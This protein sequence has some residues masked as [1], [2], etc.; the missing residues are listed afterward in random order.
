VSQGDYYAGNDKD[1]INLITPV[2]STS[3]LRVANSSIKINSGSSDVYQVGKVEQVN[4]KPFV[5]S[6]V[7][8][9]DGNSSNALPVN[10][11]DR[12]I[13]FDSISNGIQ[14]P[15]KITGGILTSYE[16]LY[17][18]PFNYEYDSSI[19][20]SYL[21]GYEIIHTMVFVEKDISSP[22]GDSLKASPGNTLNVGPAFNLGYVIGKQGCIGCNVGL[23]SNV[24]V[25]SK[26]YSQAVQ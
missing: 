8:I 12:A 10:L 16:N 5:N 6:L 17:Q 19:D 11:W 23:L 2:F 25:N 4:D 9:F 21:A 3:T 22:T 18:R 20:S 15:P 13:S 7:S 1:L 24:K 26:P 14:F